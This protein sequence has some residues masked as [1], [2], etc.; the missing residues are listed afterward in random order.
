KSKWCLTTKLPLRGGRAEVVGLVGISHDITQ[1]RKAEEARVQL[2][3]LERQ[4]RAA[5]EAAAEALRASEEQYRSLA[6]A[7]PQ[8]VLTAAADGRVDYHNRR[9]TE[10]TGL[11]AA[12]LA[13]AGWEEA[14][15]PDDR[16]KWRDGWEE[17][18]RSGIAYEAEYRVWWAGEDTH[19]WHLVRAMPVHDRSFREGGSGRVVRWF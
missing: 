1:R 12:Q 4:A 13:G 6:E 19:R 7:I 17:A 8:L 16:Q 2:L 5:A 10:Y 9:W 11:V 14:L 15:H 3:A 18:V